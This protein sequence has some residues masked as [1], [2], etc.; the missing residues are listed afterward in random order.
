VVDNPDPNEKVKEKTFGDFFSDVSKAHPSYAKFKDKSGD[1]LFNSYT[2]LESTLGSRVKLPDE[3]STPEDKKAFWAKLGVPDEAGGYEIEL[4]P[5]YGLDEAGLEQLKSA[6]HQANFTKEQSAIIQ[7]VLNQGAQK[8]SAETTQAQEA[9]AKETESTLRTEWGANFEMNRA[10]AK[11]A[12]GTVFGDAEFERLNKANG[13]DAT[14]I[15]GMHKIGSMLAEKGLLGKTTVKELG[16]YTP[17]EASSMYLDIINNKENA[18]YKAY[19]DKRNPQHQQVQDK[20]LNL[21]R[22]TTT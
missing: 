15:K 13:N 12:V 5:Y 21:I 9:I 22:V 10:L 1:D 7:G 2:N 14:F 17:E 18:E 4:D 11:R 19:H 20:V 3:K 8:L 16:G 6:F